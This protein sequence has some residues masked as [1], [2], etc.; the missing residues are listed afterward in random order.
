M[1][2]VMNTICKYLLSAYELRR[3]GRRGGESA[4]PWESKSMWVFYIELTTGKYL[5]G[6]FEHN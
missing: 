5:F 2:S 3:A 1:A 4:P 6:F